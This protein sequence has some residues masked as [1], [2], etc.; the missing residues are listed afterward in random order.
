MINDITDFLPKYPNINNNFEIDKNFLNPYTEDFYLSIFKKKEFYD[1]KLDKNEQFPK[2]GEFLKHQKINYRDLLNKKSAK[3]YSN[4][5]EL[6]KGLFYKTFTNLMTENGKEVSK[7]YTLD[8]QNFHNTL[9]EMLDAFEYENEKDYKD[10]MEKH[11]NTELVNGI[12]FYP[13]NHISE[14]IALIM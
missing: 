4:S 5:T 8:A 11:K 2:K 12:K 1:L 6:V 10:F 13:I 9:L 3:E 14:A 7:I